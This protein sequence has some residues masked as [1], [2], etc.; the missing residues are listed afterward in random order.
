MSTAV[1]TGVN[2]RARRRVD[3]GR[4]LILTVAG[5]FF[6]LPF[7]ALVE[8]ST[9]GQTL[10]SPR[11]FAA[12]RA[13]ANVGPMAEAIVASLALAAVTSIAALILVTPTMIWVRL[14]LPQFARVLQFLC[15]LPL[16]IPAIALVVGLVPIYKWVAY[17]F[18]I[19]PVTLS[20]C[21]VIFVL[22]YVYSAL[23]AGL[24]AIN[25]K[26]LSEAA[27]SLGAGWATVIIRVI[28]PNM[29][30]ALLNA[31]LLAVALV[32]G[33][34][35]A[36]SLLNFSTMPV[37]MAILGSQEVNLS[38]A[39]SAASMMFA[40]ALLLIMTVFGNRRSKSRRTS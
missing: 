16:T 32:L 7:L 6:G 13:I 40:F 35:T 27:R 25:L 21:Y 2:A 17:Y 33:E 11:T 19:S 1:S 38:I 18:G 24:G 22:P 20:F 39:V 26:T 5:I 36:A 3:L 37:Q 34:F 10:T 12:W 15:L 31:G 23:D 28:V 29:A 30:S 14:R 8:F 4:R 9:R